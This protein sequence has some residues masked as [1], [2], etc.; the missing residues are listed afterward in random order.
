[1]I[2]KRILRT[3]DG[4]HEVAPIKKGIIDENN[5]ERKLNEPREDLWGW[6]K[7]E[8]EATKNA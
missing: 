3:G 4:S 2:T 7:I 1:M 5:N 6:G 8:L